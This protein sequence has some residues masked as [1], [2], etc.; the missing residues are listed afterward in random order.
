MSK[1]NMQ[2][3]TCKSLLLL[4][5]I[6][7]LPATA[8]AE[9]L[10]VMVVTA[11]RTAKVESEAPASVTVVTEREIENKHAHRIDEALQGTPGVF[12]RSLDG[13]QPSNW[14]NQITLR[15]VPG[16]Y[17][18]GVLLDGVPLNN[19]FSGG[20]NMSVVP[21]EDIQQI[22]VV[23]GP[24]SSLYGGAGMS[25]VINIITKEPE[26]RELS[27][28]AEG[29]SHNLRSLSTSYR[30]RFENGVGFSLSYNHK[31]A[32][33]YVKELVTKTPSGA[34]GTL[35]TGWEK[36]GT[37]TGGTTYIVGDKGEQSWEVDNLSAKL[38]LP[39]SDVSKLILS[40]SHLDTI[41]YGAEGE[42]YLRAGGVPFTS[43]SAQ[44]DGARTTIR[45]TDFLR[46][47]NAEEV[48]RYAVNYK[49]DLANGGNLDASLSYQD[50]S[51]WYTSITSN[52]TA[53]QGPG[54]I[55]DI[56][57]SSINGDVHIGL[58]MGDNHYLLLGLSGNRSELNK[59][60]YALSN[61]TEEGDKGALGDY[62]N[63][64][65]QLFALYAQD[66][67]S[68]SPDL[69][70]YV[71]A[72]YDRWTTS[73]DIFI[74]SILTNYSNRSSSAFSP[75]VSLVY[76]LSGSTVIKGAIGKAFRAPNL[77]DM[78]STFGTST[79]YWS[80]PDLK[81]E[82]VTSAELSVEHQLS[83]AT[84]LRA[85]TYASRYRDLIYTTTSGIDRIKLNAG[86]AET[87]GL[88]LELRH[89]LTRNIN[90][91]INA[92]WVDTE[93]TENEVRPE[94]VGKKIPLQASRLANVGIQGDY[95][96]WSGSVIGSYTGKMYSKDDNSDTESGVPG[97]YDAYLT[98]NAKLGYRLNDNWSA[99]LAI[100]NM[101]DREYYQGSYLA[102]ERSFYL[103][104]N[105]HF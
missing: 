29:G 13:E 46:A 79:I 55:S 103:G 43:G 50:N 89:A 7:C 61:W 56:P 67:I 8:S 11:T 28:R 104:L 39:L 59:K 96:P 51:Y 40:A 2:G 36:T 76:D 18:T 3:Y 23:P 45:V 94:S 60:V 84:K 21:M 37:T 17:R 70:A 102:D 48:T 4:A 86:S 25:G 85:T 98:V 83:S 72:R 105:A 65:S 6:I 66:E 75:K 49:R 33:G 10:G 74:N 47:S 71:G 42:S 80:N 77:S 5:L 12:I 63:G 90:T 16:Y 32:D 99:D 41:S 44:I 88:D 78:Y 95:G 22:E 73:G 34:G 38:Y 35:V 9:Y 14:Q 1:N 62:A 68:L 52:S 27:V 93:I 100:K 53:T 91:F 101:F 30:D 92:T 58:P 31:E 87:K 69:T 82:T 64:N 20:V 57:A 26:E 19:A 24:F 54:S 15:G 81:P 97:S